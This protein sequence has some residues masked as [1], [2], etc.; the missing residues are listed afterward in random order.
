MKR[1]TPSS[2][3]SL[4]EVTLALGVAGFCLIAIFGLLPVALNSN[5]A[6]VEQTAANGILSAVL[7]D[8]RATPPGGAATSKQYSIAIPAGGAAATT[9]PALFF[10]SE[11]QLVA[12]AQGRYRVTIAFTG[13][14]AGGGARSATCASVKVTWPAPVDPAAAG[15]RPAGSVM[16]FL[17]LDRN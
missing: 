11:Q 8:L 4:I 2:G 15:A 1:H 17:A 6:A 10:N 12:Q 7:S 5:Q 3:F 13:P 14:P 16:N 9:A